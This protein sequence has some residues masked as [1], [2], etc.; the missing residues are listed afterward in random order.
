MP[1]R[2]MRNILRRG[3]LVTMNEAMIPLMR[4]QQFWETVQ[5]YKS[6][7]L[8]IKMTLGRKHTI[9]SRLRMNTSPPHHVQDIRKII[10]EQCIATPLDEQSNH[11]SNVNTFPHTGCFQHVP[12]R[13]P[14]IFQLSFDSPSDL[15]HLART[16]S[17][18][19]SP[20]A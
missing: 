14:S 8:S 13:L 2:L 17:E 19:L 20:S 15:S 11:S 5:A 1:P 4:S 7:D 12:P 18:S 9:N 6:N 3:N 10:G 16:K